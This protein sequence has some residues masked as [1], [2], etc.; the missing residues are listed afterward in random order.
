[1]PQKDGNSVQEMVANTAV[2]SQKH[3][4]EWASCNYVFTLGG[5][6]V[7]MGECSSEAIER[8]CTMGLWVDLRN[9][10]KRF[11]LYFHFSIIE[12]L[13]HYV[14]VSKDWHTNCV[15]SLLDFSI[16]FLCCFLG[17]FPTYQISSNL[18]H[19]RQLGISFPL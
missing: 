2:G 11:L 17:N 15:F 7:G 18:M 19:L 14:D 3:Y 12:K 13:F 6:K 16:I 1:M 5:A 10:E 4:R 9:Q 8:V